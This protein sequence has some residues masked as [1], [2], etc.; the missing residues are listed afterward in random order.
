MRNRRLPF[1]T[2][3]ALVVLATAACGTPDGASPASAA[4]PKAVPSTAVSTTA[5]G[6]PGAATGETA[7]PAASGITLRVTGPA[8]ET[9]RVTYIINTASTDQDGVTLPWQKTVNPLGNV[10]HVSL[11][12]MAEDTG[13]L[14]CEIFVDGL[15]VHATQASTATA[16]VASCEWTGQA[17]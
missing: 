9:A 10:T 15:Q 3:A 14:G 6:T 1:V 5:S 8:A 13:E 11:I 4:T 17:G 7:A 12:A 16:G 2:A